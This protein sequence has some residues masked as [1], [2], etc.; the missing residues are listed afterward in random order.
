[1]N[2]SSYDA[3]R[4]RRFC[5]THGHA[6]ESD[7]RV[8]RLNGHKLGEA[9]RNSIASWTER[10]PLGRWDELLLSVGLM[11]WQYETWEQ[12]TYGDLSFRE[13]AAPEQTCHDC[14]GAGFDDD[15]DCQYCEGWGFFPTPRLP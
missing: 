5:A 10:A 1:M 14:G 3:D 9:F 15:G 12:E 13:V 4:V 8:M 6:R 2:Q 7:G 11:L